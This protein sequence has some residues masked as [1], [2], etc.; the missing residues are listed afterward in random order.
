VSA[1]SVLRC[2]AVRARQAWSTGLYRDDVNALPLTT[3]TGTLGLLVAAHKEARSGTEPFAASD[4]RLL[5][6]FAIQVTV[7]LEYARLTR[8][9][10]ERELLKQELEAAA[11]IQSHLYPRAFPEFPGYRIAASSR[12]SRQVAGDTYDVLVQD[13]FLV[14]TVTDVSGKGTGAGMI[15]SGVHAG[16]HLLLQE[17]LPL[18]ELSGRINRYLVGSTADNRFATFVVSR[19]GRDGSLVVVNAGHCPVLIRRADGKVDAI[20][21]S[22]VPLG[23]FANAYFPEQHSQLAAGILPFTDGLPEAESPEGRAQRR[24][25]VVAGLEARTAGPASLL[26]PSTAMPAMST[27][28]R[29]HPAGAGAPASKR[30]PTERLARSSPNRARRRAVGSQWSF[31]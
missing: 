16:V 20:G 18:P 17:A 31:R 4:A 5:E 7:A 27:A 25:G 10:L 2:S 19:I 9:S 29:R 12:P 3:S 15:A 22:A 30:G 6:L 26:A 21:S 24:E 23:I 11:A 8:E 1:A 13:G 14:T 28:G